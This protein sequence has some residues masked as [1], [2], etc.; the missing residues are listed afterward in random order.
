VSHPC[1]NTCPSCCLQLGG[2]RDLLLLGCLSLLGAPLGPCW[3]PTNTPLLLQP[4]VGG[5]P[6]LDLAQ[7]MALRQTYQRVVARTQAEELISEVLTSGAALH[8]RPARRTSH[9][10]ASHL[11][12]AVAALTSSPPPVHQLI[13]LQQQQ[14]QQQQGAAGARSTMAASMGLMGGDKGPAGVSHLSSLVS[15]CLTS[16]FLS[17]ITQPPPWYAASE[18]RRSLLARL[19]RSLVAGGPGAPLSGHVGAA[20]A[21]LLVEATQVAGGEGSQS[22]GHQHQLSTQ[23]MAAS[24]QAPCELSRVDRARETAKA[25]LGV[26]RTNLVLWG[27][28][29]QLELMCGGSKASK[30]SKTS[31]SLC[32]MCSFSYD[33][34]LQELIRV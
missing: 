13:A 5:Q 4:E 31:R 14:Q 10:I 15:P 25:L 7:Q 34:V 32:A 26:Q 18:E 23:L 29:A 1:F 28:Y 8:T 22:S 20:L 12:P 3:A 27:A 2:P 9:A 11:S 30:V 19:L 33:S 16:A 24:C 21:L 6:P 17:P